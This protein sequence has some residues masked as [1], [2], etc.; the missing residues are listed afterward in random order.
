VRC[1][2]HFFGHYYS[3]ASNEA[4]LIVAGPVWSLLM[5]NIDKRLASS[6][7]RGAFAFMLP[8]QPQI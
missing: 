5:R 1:P 4:G 8:G 2:N 7:K 3:A 6:P